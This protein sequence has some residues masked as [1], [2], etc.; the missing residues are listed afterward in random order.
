[1]ILA[2]KSSADHEI[3]AAWRVGVEAFAGFDAQIAGCNH[4]GQQG[5]GSVFR[6][7]KAVMQHF[8]NGM[9][10]IKPDEVCQLQG[11]HRVG[12]SQLHYGINFLYA[13]DAFVEAVN[14]LVD[15]GHQDAV[16]YK[17]GIIVDDAGDLP[18]LSGD[19]HHFFGDVFIRSIAVDDL[20]KL[21]DGNG[22]HK[23]ETDDG[24]G[25]PGYG[26]DLCN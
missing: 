12:H 8:Q 21:H 2:A 22:V 19:L 20:Y 4:I 9:T 1:M 10:D 24:S 23:V 5:A 16:G 18:Q 25:T 26:C 14:G 11:A 17:S 6:V 7:T 13:G 3:L 15:H